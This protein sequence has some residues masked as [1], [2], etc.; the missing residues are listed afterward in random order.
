MKTIHAKIG[1]QT[2]TARI[3]PGKVDIVIKQGRRTLKAPPPEP[4][5]LT[6]GQKAARQREATEARILE[7]YREAK[8]TLEPPYDNWIWLFNINP[9]TKYSFEQLNHHLNRLLAGKYPWKIGG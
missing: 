7:I 8:T 9:F 1:G 2:I 6:P 4:L 5:A 3:G